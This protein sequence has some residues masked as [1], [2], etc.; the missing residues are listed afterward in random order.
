MSADEDPG[1]RERRRAR[2][3]GS[4]QGLVGA[5]LGTLLFVGW[6]RTVGSIVL[7]V[8]ALLLGSAWASPTG[9]YAAIRR[10]LQTLGRLTGAALT[11]LL[12]PPVFYLFFLPFGAL[13]RRGRRDRLRRI[14]DPDAPTYWEAHAGLTAG[15][16]SYERQY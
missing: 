16:G 3:E 4:L 14:L 8:G 12:L 9:L 5:A 2:L 7:G 13:L 10:L 11:W 6:S 1:R 15:S